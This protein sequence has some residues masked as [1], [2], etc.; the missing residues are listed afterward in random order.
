MN[1]KEGEWPQ[2][3]AYMKGHDAWRVRSVFETLASSLA[4]ESNLKRTINMM[5]K[6]NNV[7]P[8]ICVYW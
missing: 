2:V 1:W 4:D 7:F 8:A 6:E 3:F 5:M